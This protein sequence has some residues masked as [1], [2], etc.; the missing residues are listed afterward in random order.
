M[1]TAADAP[2]APHP[3]ST[4]RRILRY[5][6]VTILIGFVVFVG[7]FSIAFSLLSQLIAIAFGL[8]SDAD[9]QVPLDDPAL[10]WGQLFASLIL[11]VLAILAYRFVIV[12]WCEGRA[13]AP[14]LAFGSRARSWVPLGLLLGAGVAL[15]SVAFLALAGGGASWATSSIASGIAW[16]L[17][18]SIFAGVIE[19]LFARGT[20]LRV[21]E[22][23]IGS[24]AAIV[25]SSAIFGI[26][27]ADNPNASVVSTLAVAL[28][29]GAMLGLVYVVSRTLWAPIA[30]HFAWNF[31]QSVLTIPVSGN[32]TFGAW[33]VTFDGPDWLT[34]GAFGLE[35]SA[36]A[37]GL[38]VVVTIVLA[39]VAARRHLGQ[40]WRAARAAVADGTAREPVGLPS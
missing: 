27:H 5:P 12:R 17:G 30:V 4:F 2:V 14:E 21:S 36:I 33:Q 15:V 20:L 38:W 18:M 29:G 40:S 16:A 26:Q 34:G 32:E 31:T 1:S 6:L 22:Q 19:E 7:L 3:D 37:F 11:A 9:G 25:L 10:G 23:H 28:E 39:V 13:S 35:P 24:A 8:R